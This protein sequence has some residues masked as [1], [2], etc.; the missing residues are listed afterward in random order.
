MNVMRLTCKSGAVFFIVAKTTTEAIQALP[1]YNK[2][3][4]KI[5]D[6][7]QDAPV[8]VCSAA[9][10][11]H[12]V[13]MNTPTASGDFT[14]LPAHD[15]AE[16]IG[17][18]DLQRLAKERDKQGNPAVLG[19]IVLHNPAISAKSADEPQLDPVEEMNREDSPA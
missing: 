3:L 10:V 16:S 2:D 1:Q 13:Q 5:E 6:V 17:S 4:V 9:G 11:A 15:G 7:S 18:D 19:N 8:I 12:A 14:P